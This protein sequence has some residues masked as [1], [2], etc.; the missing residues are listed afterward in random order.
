[1]FAFNRDIINGTCALPVPYHIYEMYE[2]KG[3]F[4]A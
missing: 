1:M 4:E 2:A 3:N